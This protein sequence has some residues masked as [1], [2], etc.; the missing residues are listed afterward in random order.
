MKLTT[1]GKERIKKRD[2]YICRYCGST[3][4]LF[5]EVDHLRAKS[6]GGDNISSNLVCSCK[7]CNTLK[8]S[9]SRKNFKEY[10]D[11]LIKLKRMKKLSISIIVRF[12][13]NG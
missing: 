12:I 10:L 4:Q 7:L 3:N 9:L 2:G 13:L 8:G 11:I 6:K 5:L 1:K